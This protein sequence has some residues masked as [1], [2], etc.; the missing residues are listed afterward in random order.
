MLHR[1]ARIVKRAIGYRNHI[2]ELGNMA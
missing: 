1:R 2:A